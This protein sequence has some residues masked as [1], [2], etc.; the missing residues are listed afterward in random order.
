M[1]KSRDSVVVFDKSWSN[2]RKHWAIA[3]WTADVKLRH[4]RQLVFSIQQ[5]QLRFVGCLKILPALLLAN[6]VQ[7]GFWPGNPAGD[8]FTCTDIFDQQLFL[9]W[10]NSQIQMPGTS[11]R[12]FIAALEDMSSLNARVGIFNRLF[13]LLFFFYSLKGNITSLFYR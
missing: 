12:C 1:D 11:E 2:H 7:S 8:S 6:I 10:H 3:Q 13:L 9:Q 4:K 5:T